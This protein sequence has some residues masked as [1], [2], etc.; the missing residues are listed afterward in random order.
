MGPYT[1][2][3]PTNDAFKTISEPLKT[4]M[5]SDMKYFVLGHV[6]KGSYPMNKLTKSK[7]NY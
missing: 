3:V 4:K 7:I 1:L 6:T 5:K 2:F